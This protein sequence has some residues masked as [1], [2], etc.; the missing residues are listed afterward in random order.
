VI[1]CF[2]TRCLIKKKFNEKTESV[3]IGGSFQFSEI[4]ITSIEI[5]DDSTGAEMVESYD[6]IADAIYGR[7]VRIADQLQ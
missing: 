4:G 3:K 7:V 6:I 1:Q 2:P 5:V